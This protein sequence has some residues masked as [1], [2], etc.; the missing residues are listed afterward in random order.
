[1]I[2]VNFKTYPESTGEHAVKLAI[3]CEV[4]SEQTNIP[5]IPVVQVADLWRVTQHV[6]IPV[7]IQHIDPHEQGKHTGF[8][9]LEAVM[10]SNAAGTLINHSEHTLNEKTLELT[11]GRIK[12]LKGEFLCLICAADQQSVKNIRQFQ[13]DYIAYE[14][15]ELIG[16]T[17]DS[18][19]T[20]Y[21]DV[22]T[23]GVAAADGVPLIV[24]AGVKDA[25]DIKISIEQGARGVLVASSVITSKDP[26]KILTELVSG[27]TAS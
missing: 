2:F 15:P 16:S 8:T 1:M 6:H 21:V 5:V 13:P 9:T 19:A 23:Q 12:E 27:F 26:Q 25:N 17:T 22:I 24:G 3:T 18:V 20:K 14:P 4:V 10:A 7:W 11:M